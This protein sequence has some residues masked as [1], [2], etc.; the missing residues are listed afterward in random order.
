MAESDASNYNED[1]ETTKMHRNPSTD[2]EMP[3]GTRICTGEEIQNLDRRCVSDFNLS[4]DQL[5]E[6]AG[7]AAAKLI[8]N[9]LTDAS[10]YHAFVYA[11]KGGNA[12]DA[13]VVARYLSTRC[14]NVTVICLEDETQFQG[15]TLRKWQALAAVKAKI[16][17]VTSPAAWAKLALPACERGLIVDG[18]L[19]TGLRGAPKA[20][21]LSAIEQINACE[22]PVYALDIAS[23]VNADLGTVEVAAVKAR[24]TIAFGFSKRGHF[25]PPG[26]IHC[27]KLCVVDIDYPRDLNSGGSAY[28]VEAQHIRQMLMPR[29]PYGFKNTFGHAY[30]VGGSEGKVGAPA[31]SAAAAHR[32]G[33]GLVTAATWKDSAGVLAVKVGL[34]TM[35]E[36]LPATASAKKV[37]AV[38]LDRFS[39]VAIGP[40]LGVTTR[41]R[42]L[43]LQVI[44]KYLGPLVLDADA[45]TL[46]A[47]YELL[48]RLKKR[49]GSTILTPHPGE[50]ARLLGVPSSV[51]VADGFTTSCK[52]A[53]ISG[54]IAIIK[55]S[56]TFVAGPGQP[57]MAIRAPNDGM[58]KAGSGDILT[59]LICGLLAQKQTPS[60]AALVGVYLH[61][62]AGRFAAKNIGTRALIASDLL[63]F[64]SLAWR[65][66]APT[67]ECGK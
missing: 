9:E 39:S 23:G 3:P 40:G 44:E 25:L 20:H 13:F 16:I 29:S 47:Q 64:T 6:N 8:L 7:R 34:T 41:A 15:A 33:A 50:A 18:L 45:L 26:T 19:G 14:R 58:A 17:T 61:Q 32:S 30:I 51:V 62:L 21:Y 53:E 65:D 11:G 31:L 66:L 2:P 49:K 22:L 42:D 4:S 56:T 60:S 5:M 48:D 38:S 63:R 28:L 55:G 52:L 54:S 12:G 24:M 1:G 59:G 37:W 43:I 67:L 27:G 36:A 10:R 46:L 35:S 57:V